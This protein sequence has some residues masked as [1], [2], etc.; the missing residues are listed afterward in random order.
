MPY[1]NM[2]CNSLVSYSI[3]FF[4]AFFHLQQKEADTF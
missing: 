3:F 1:F 2:I 4:V